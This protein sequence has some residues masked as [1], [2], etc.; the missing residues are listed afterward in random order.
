MNLAI[1]YY[2]SDNHT[3]QQELNTTTQT[4]HQSQLFD[5]IIN[6][7]DHPTHQQL[8]QL[9]A[10]ITSQTQIHHANHPHRPKFNQIIQHLNNHYPQQTCI[11]AN[12]DITFNKTILYTHLI[13][14]HNQIICL[15]RWEPTSNTW[16]ENVIKHFRGQWCQDKYQN[17]N[18]H[19]STSQDAWIFETPL[20]I[21]LHQADFTQGILGC[22]KITK[23]AQQAG[24]QTINPCQTIKC[25]HNHQSQYRTYDPTHYL[26]HQ[27]NQTEPIY[28]C[29]HQ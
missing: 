29:Y 7:S 27:L 2:I 16:Q 22:E 26:D 5:T 11:I 3:R 1:N 9:L 18:H 14:L 20:K 13:N 21:P 6:F 8:Q 15:T 28:L 23:I 24:Y 25:Y 4:N 17:L 12:L 19:S 10:P